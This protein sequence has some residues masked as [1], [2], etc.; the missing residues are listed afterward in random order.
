ME[1]G[2]GPRGRLG[3]GVAFSVDGLGS[4]REGAGDRWGTLSAGVEVSAR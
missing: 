4:L 1:R 3:G 2:R